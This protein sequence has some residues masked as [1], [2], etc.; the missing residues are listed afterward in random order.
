MGAN[1]ITGVDKV[2]AATICADLYETGHFLI[3]PPGYAYPWNSPY[4][5]IPI[6]PNAFMPNDDS[7]FYNLAIEKNTHP[8]GW[9]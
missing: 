4:R 5:K 9:V 3:K 1:D 7:P 6:L 2:T 8:Y